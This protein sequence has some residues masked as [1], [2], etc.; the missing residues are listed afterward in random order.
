M[1]VVHLVHETLNNCILL[2]AAGSDVLP[3]I[4]K[5]MSLVDFVSEELDCHALNFDDSSLLAQDISIDV[6][7]SKLLDLALFAFKTAVFARNRAIYYDV[8][9]D[10]ALLHEKDFSFARFKFIMSV[11]FEKCFSFDSLSIN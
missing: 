3:N 8:L 10:P 5:V 11:L 4:S 9:Y 1:S 2:H 7:V 6:S